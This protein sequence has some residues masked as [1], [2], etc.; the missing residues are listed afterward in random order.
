MRSGLDPT[1]CQS[2]A[3]TRYGEGCVNLRVQVRLYTKCGMN[4][5]CSISQVY[6]SQT[7]TESA[8]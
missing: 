1:S 8:N 2:A 5:S 4:Q 6:V 7:V 3:E